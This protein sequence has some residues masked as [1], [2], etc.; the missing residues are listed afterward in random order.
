M[1]NPI[2][3]KKVQGQKHPGKWGIVEH[4]IPSIK[5]LF[6]TNP[7][8]HKHPG[9]KLLSSESKTQLVNQRKQNSYRR[10]YIY[11]YINTELLDGNK[12]RNYIMDVIHYA[13]MCWMVEYH[14]VC[15][16]PWKNFWFKTRCMKFKLCMP[17]DYWPGREK[18]SL[19]HSQKVILTPLRAKFFRGNINIYLH[20][21]SLLHID[22]TQVR[23]IL[24]QVRPGPTYSTQS[25]SWPLMSWRRKEPGHQQPWYWP[26]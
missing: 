9:I 6:K 7:K 12:G 17:R 11:L 23:K 26:S 13:E 2:F 24:P 4:Q 15:N 14:F 25:V 5:V 1:L 20:F 3:W 22:M 19:L 8:S 10:A 16:F 21:M 18:I